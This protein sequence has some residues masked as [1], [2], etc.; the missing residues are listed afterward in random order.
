MKRIGKYFIPVQNCGRII[1]TLVWDNFGLRYSLEEKVDPKYKFKNINSRDMYASIQMTQC[2][3]FDM[4]NSIF[5]G[6]V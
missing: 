1:S 6:K 4:R 2:K 3:I 5:F